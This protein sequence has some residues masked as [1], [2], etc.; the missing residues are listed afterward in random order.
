MLYFALKHIHVTSV[1]FSGSFFFLRGLWM[2]RNSAMLDR[3]WVRIA[4]HC[5]DTA[6][7]ASAITLAAWSGQY[8]FVQ[9]WLSA[10]VI[11]LAAYI[12]LGTVALKR[13]RT[14][15]I[16]VGAFVAALAVFFYIVAVALTKRAAIFA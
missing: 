1:V 7:L 3:R 4:P 16:R 9:S 15:T 8:P 11:A 12:M 5:I 14:K 10:K 2:L 13:G 6:L